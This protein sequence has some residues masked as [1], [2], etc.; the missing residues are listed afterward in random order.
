[1]T[2]DTDHAA[3]DDVR[4]QDRARSSQLHPV[5]YKI[6]GGLLVWMILAAWGFFSDAGYSG[7]V[8]MIVTGFAIMILA[9]PYE[10]WRLWRRERDHV[11]QRL[12]EARRPFL[13]WAHGRLDV[14]QGSLR[15]SEAA[16]LALVP[17]AAGAVGMTALVIVLHI[18]TQ[19]SWH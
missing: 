13:E 15:G 6:A 1:M 17:L 7:L 12:P 5:V 16:L 14:W 2:S 3:E 10:L 9:V 19:G 8:L 4:R 11:P 18:A